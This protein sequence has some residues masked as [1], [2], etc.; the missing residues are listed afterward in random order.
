[1]RSGAMALVAGNVE[2]DR[3]VDVILDGVLLPS[4]DCLPA[5]LRLIRLGPQVPRVQR[6]AAIFQ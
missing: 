4:A 6:M 1:M 3:I 5:D 2:A